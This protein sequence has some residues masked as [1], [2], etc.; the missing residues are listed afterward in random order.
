MKTCEA[1]AALILLFCAGASTITEALVFL[2]DVPSPSLLIDVQA[3]Q[4]DL[5]S[6]DA[7]IPP[8]VLPKSG[9]RLLAHNIEEELQ[10]PSCRQLQPQP[11]PPHTFDMTLV[12]D[13]FDIG[14]NNKNSLLQSASGDT[15]YCYIHSRVVRPRDDRNED[16]DDEQFVVELDVPSQ[17]Q[18]SDAHLVLGLNNHHVG[19]YY[20]ARSAGA[21]AAM[22]APGFVLQQSKILW[23]SNEGFID[24]N[25]ND[26]KRSEWVAFLRKNDQVQ[27]RP[28]NTEDILIKECFDG[29]TIYGVSAVGRPLG[30]E[31]VVVCKWVFQ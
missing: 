24:C 9:R 29:T 31:P 18:S 25:S 27:L 22:E 20:W 2:S 4:K 15:C 3:I 30:S 19:S 26:G 14:D 6:K 8:L 13:P 17:L 16:D 11:Q 10:Q 1:A 5:G 21:G 12:D 23:E 28:E 7:P